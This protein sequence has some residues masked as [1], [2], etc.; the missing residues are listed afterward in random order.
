MYLAVPMGGRRWSD[1]LSES[2]TAV[3]MLDLYKLSSWSPALKEAATSDRH[4]TVVGSYKSLL[5]N[6][7][8]DHQNLKKADALLSL[9][10]DLASD[11]VGVEVGLAKYK[12]KIPVCVVSP[13]KMA[14]VTHVEA[15]AVVPTLQSACKWL[16]KRLR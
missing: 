11:G 10:G 16:S 3:E 13:R 8:I 1:V 15:D 6:W 14:R 2:L 4:N 5:A 9:R 7:K 12:Y